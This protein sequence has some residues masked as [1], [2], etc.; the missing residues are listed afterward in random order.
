MRKQ[1]PALLGFQPW[2]LELLQASRGCALPVHS[3]SILRCV[4]PW[5]NSPLLS[6]VS[7]SVV[8]VT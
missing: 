7:L 1:N 3:A 4:L 8:L 2:S 5:L 6:V